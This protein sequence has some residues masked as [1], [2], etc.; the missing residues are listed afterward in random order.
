MGTK[1]DYDHDKEQTI[2]KPDVKRNTASLDDA[3]PIYYDSEPSGQPPQYPNNQSTQR[4]VRPTSSTTLQTPIKPPHQHRNSAPAATIN[5]ILAS[6]HVDLDAERRANRKN[7]TLR[8]RWRDFMDRTFH[9]NYEKDEWR[10]ARAKGPELNVWGT[11]LKA[12]TP[13][14][15]ER[16]ARR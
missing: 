9:N 12:S 6:P 10:V 13:T 8:E 2:S 7:K 1:S 3:P 14:P 16:K 4:Q 5:A 15:L 11:R